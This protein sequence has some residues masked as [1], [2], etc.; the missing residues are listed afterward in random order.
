MTGFAQRIGFVGINLLLVWHVF[1]IAISPASMPPAS[2]LLADASTVARPYN[3]AL[4]LN[5]GYHYFAPNPGASSLL[6]FQTAPDNDVPEIA[7]IPDP[8]SYFPRLRYHRF[9]ML[10][11]N[12]W[13]FGEQPQREFIEAYARHFAGELHSDRVSVVSVSHDPASM[14][15]IVAGGELNDPSSY[16]REPLA[17]FEFAED[18]RTISQS[19][20]Y[21]TGIEPDVELSPTLI[22]DPSQTMEP[23]ESEGPAAFAEP[24]S[25]DHQSLEQTDAPAGDG[26]DVE[27]SHGFL[28]PVSVQ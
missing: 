13:A 5:H 23:E 25:V 7:R 27:V 20:A 28:P 9:F 24:L 14:R 19:F 18:G 17:E 8:E 21:S 1:A 2:P 26:E 3:Q 10:S 6:E 16:A 12:V 11:E 22:A 15:R 4:F